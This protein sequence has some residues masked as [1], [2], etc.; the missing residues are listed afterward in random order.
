MNIEVCDALNGA[1]AVV[2]DNL[3]IKTAPKKLCRIC[4]RSSN[5]IPLTLSI[6]L[7]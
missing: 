5:N 3:Y 2:R 7:W 1:R 6:L 4:M